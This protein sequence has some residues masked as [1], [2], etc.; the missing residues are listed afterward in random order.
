MFV[1]KKRG[2][3]NVC[4]LQENK[5]GDGQRQISIIIN[6]GYE[7]KI[8]GRTLFHNFGFTKCIQFY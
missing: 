2:I 1:P 6:G 8:Q 4:G 7:N 3:E 5:C